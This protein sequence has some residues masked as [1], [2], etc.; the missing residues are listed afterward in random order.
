MALC[1]CNIVAF[2]QVRIVLQELFGMNFLFADAKAGKDSF[3]NLL[4]N[5]FGFEA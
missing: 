1:N 4:V 2:Y 3:E 5:M